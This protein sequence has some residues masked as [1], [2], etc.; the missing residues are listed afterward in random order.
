VKTRPLEN[1]QV[2][3]I[4]TPQFR[5][6]FVIP[7]LE[8]IG[9]ATVTDRGDPRGKAKANFGLLAWNQQK[10]HKEKKPNSCKGIRLPTFQGE[11]NVNLRL[12][13]TLPKDPILLLW[14]FCPKIAFRHQ[15]TK[16]QG[17]LQE[18]GV[19]LGVRNSSLSTEIVFSLR[20]ELTSYVCPEDR[21]A[22]ST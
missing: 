17:A 3:P 13:R 19:P 22:L 9:G 21:K 12:H 7:S 20:F 4:S 5:T 14:L 15:K 18:V 16:T 6:A 2:Y 1:P 8:L 10:F 11:K